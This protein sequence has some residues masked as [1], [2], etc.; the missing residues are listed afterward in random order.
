VVHGIQP[1]KAI[2]ALDNIN[3]PHCYTDWLG[4]DPR[5]LGE[6][7]LALAAEMEAAG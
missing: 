7:L 1:Y 3:M 2:E 5:G 4:E 6:W